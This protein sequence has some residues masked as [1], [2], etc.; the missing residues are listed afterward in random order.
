MWQPTSASTAPLYDPHETLDQYRTRK[1]RAFAAFAEAAASGRVKRRLRWFYDDL[2]DRVGANRYAWVSV[3]TLAAAYA[4]DEATIKRWL[5][6]LEQAALIRRQRR[7]GASSLTY[8]TAYDQCNQEHVLEE[9]RCEVLTSDHQ[10]DQHQPVEKPHTYRQ[11]AKGSFFGPADAP[12]IS[13]EMRQDSIKCRHLTR[14]VGGPPRPREQHG[15]TPGDAGANAAVDPQIEALLEQEQVADFMLAPQLRRRSLRELQAVSQYLTTQRNVR[16]RARLFAALVR[17]GFGARLLTG[18]GAAKPGKRG[19]R[20]APSPA[21]NSYAAAP[22]DPSISIPSE[23]AALWRCT[24]TALRATIDLPAWETWL[25]DTQLVALDGDLA[26]IATPTVFSRHQLAQDYLPLIAAALATESGQ[27][28]RVELVIGTVPA[29]MLDD[30]AQ[31][32]IGVGGAAAA[33]PPGRHA[34]LPPESVRY[35]SG[36][37]AHLIHW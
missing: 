18:Q 6:A 10:Y 23:L 8:L 28:P 37:L 25:R 2:V 29:V 35:L 11:A 19:R 31:E 22:T 12:P 7:M 24:L 17:E 1:R 36:E 4:V 13:A 9:H 32:G 14:S 3:A 16:D 34:D 5:C 20:P 26:V 27:E 33:A 30:V 21:P 15:T